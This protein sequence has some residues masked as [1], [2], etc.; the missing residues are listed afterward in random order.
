MVHTAVIVMLRCPW[1]GDNRLQGQSARRCTLSVVIHMANFSGRFQAALRLSGS[2]G[3]KC[4]FTPTFRRSIFTCESRSWF[5]GKSVHA[6]LH[7]SV[8][9][10]YDLCHPIVEPKSD[11]YILTHPCHVIFKSTSDRR[12]IW[13][14][15]QPRQMHLRCKFI[16]RK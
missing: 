11:F 10:G 16:D 9:S 5:I 7:V 1:S 4:V 8:C 3:L 6:R 12:C 15:V 14:L 13:Q 2:A